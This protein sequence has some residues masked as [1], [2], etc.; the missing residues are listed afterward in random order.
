MGT[1]VFDT[2]NGN[3]RRIRFNND[4]TGGFFDTN[5]NY[6]ELTGIYTA[7][8]G[9]Y[10]HSGCTVEITNNTASGED[11]IQQIELC[12]VS[13]TGDVLEVESAFTTILN[14][15]SHT[16]NLSRTFYLQEGETIQVF[17]KKRFGLS[18]LHLNQ[19]VD[20]ND[21][22][23]GYGRNTGDTF[24]VDFLFNGGGVVPAS[25]PAEVRLLNFETE[26]SI[27]REVFD[28]I[29]ANPFKYYHTNMAP[30]SENPHYQTGYIGKISRGILNGE[31]TMTQFKKMDGV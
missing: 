26:L 17:V 5:G 25:D 27:S 1:W 7:P 8:Q 30:A 14:G 23:L 16:F 3:Y 24:G 19:Y 29:L 21:D 2:S 13:A 12:K 28:S 10:Y 15:T 22:Y 11:Y 6:D 4:S 18:G 9:G 20:W 31:C